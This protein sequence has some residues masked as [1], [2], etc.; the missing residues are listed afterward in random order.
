MYKIHIFNNC[1]SWKIFEGESGELYFKDSFMLLIRRK[2]YISAHEG[3]ERML[4]C[5]FL[6]SFQA[7]FRSGSQYQ[8][9]E[10]VLLYADWHDHLLS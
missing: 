6:L 9:R 1:V 3:E 8:R 5:S 7:G 10:S 2:T 4:L